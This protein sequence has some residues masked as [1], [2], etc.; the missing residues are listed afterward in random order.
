MQYVL[1]AVPET[2]DINSN[3][4]KYCGPVMK[5]GHTTR[6]LSCNISEDEIDAAR[7]TGR[8]M[9][10][11]RFICEKQA[12]SDLLGWRLSTQ[13]GFDPLGGMAVAHDILEHF[14]DS[15]DSVAD[16]LQALGA[17]LYIRG[18]TGYWKHRGSC[19]EPA[20]HMCANIPELLRY[21]L[22]PDKGLPAPPP[23]NLNQQDGKTFQH[24]ALKF[25]AAFP[26]YVKSEDF[27]GADVNSYLTDLIGWIKIGY[28]RAG[29]RYARVDRDALMRLF[30]SIED[31]AAQLLTSA[32]PGAV[33]EVSVSLTNCTSQV[34]LSSSK[35]EV[36]PLS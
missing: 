29:K 5:E 14:P 25:T 4:R 13:R 28:R 18:N 1:A 27:G 12:D 21:V 19:Q 20:R 15:T 9:R 33:L 16:E 36:Q 32:V 3:K 8:L 30:C 24:H 2:W 34:K 7:Q 22:R 10:T 26:H 11:H 35:S 6:G 31:Q 23:C 17:E